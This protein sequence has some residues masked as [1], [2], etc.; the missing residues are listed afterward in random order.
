MFL[1]KYYNDIFSITFMDIDKKYHIIID[2][3]ISHLKYN[4]SGILLVFLIAI[5][6]FAY[7]MPT[8]LFFSPSGTDVYTHTYNTQNMADANS[9]F[10]FYE[11]S[12][13]NE[14]MGYD[15]P[16]GMWYFGSILMKVTGMSSMELA[17]ILPLT[18]LFILLILYYIFALELL[19]SSEGAILSTIFMISMPVLAIGMLNYSTSRFVVLFLI[20][21]LFIAL[22][23]PEIK[24][25]LISLI[26]VFTL[27]FSHTGTFMFLI[28]FSVMYFLI[29]A[30]V[31]KK[32]DRGFFILIVSLLFVYVQIAQ[33]FPFV[34]PQYI[35]KGRFLITMTD[36]LASI[37]GLG[38][39][40]EMGIIFYEN[41]FV[42]SNIIYALFWSSLLYV[43]AKF[44]IITRVRIEN[45][46]APQK[47][48][49]ALPII[50]NISQISHDIVAAPFWIG[51]VHTVLAVIGF[52]KLDA[53]GKCIFLAL[54]G[55][56]LVPGM[57]K[58][59]ENTGGTTSREIFYL[60]LIIPVAA[61]AGFYVLIP[62]VKRYTVKK[63]YSIPTLGIYA[64]ILIPLIV[65]PVI[66]SI[67][68]APVISGT[69]QERTNLQ[70]L[71]TTGNSF[72]GVAGPGY[73]ERIDLYAL[74]LTPSIESGSESKRYWDDLYKT[75]FYEGAEEY[76]HDLN[77]FNIK[78]ILQSDRTLKGFLEGATSLKIS[79]N[80]MLDRIYASDNNFSIYRY[81]SPQETNP[82]ISKE[83]FPLVFTSNSTSLQKYGSLFLFENDYYKVKLGEATPG[84]RYIGTTTEDLLGGGALADLLTIT[85]S[86]EYNENIVGYSLDDLDC[87]VTHEGNRIIYR[88]T[89]YDDRNTQKWATL[90]IKYIFYEKAFKREIVIA[91]D[92]QNFESS[93]KMN[94]GMTQM[95]FAPFNG[96]E[97]MQLT[98]GFEKPV[99]KHL[100]PSEDNVVLKD[101]TFSEIFINETEKGFLIR[102]G[103]TMPYPQRLVYRGS[104]YYDGV[105]NIMFSLNRYLNPSEPF[106][107]E[108]YYAVGTAEDSRDFI[109]EYTSVSR[110]DFA[111]GITPVVITGSAKDSDETGPVRE[112][113]ERLDIPYNQIQSQKE[114]EFMTNSTPIGQVNVYSNKKYLTQAEQ[115][116]A[117]TNAL[118]NT[119]ATGSL[120]AN[121]RYNLDSIRALSNAGGVYT[122]AYTVYPLYEKSDQS[123]YRE[124]KRAYIEG[125]RT[126]II[127]FPVSLPFSY[128]LRPQYES[129]ETLQQWSDII[130]GVL[131]N[132]GIAIF[133][134]DISDLAS[135]NSLNDIEEML[136]YAVQNGISFTTLDDTAAHDLMMQNVYADV[137]RDIDEVHLSITNTNPCQVKQATYR[138]VLPTIDGA[139]P[140]VVENGIMS[141]HYVTGDTA[142]IFV[143][144]DLNPGETKEVVVHPSIERKHFLIDTN[145]LF[146]G[147]STIVIMDNDSNPVM[148]ARITV[149]GKTYETDEEGRVSLNINRGEYTAVIEKPG[150]TSVR[151]VIEVKGIIKRYIRI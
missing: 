69:E 48:F 130:T 118:K 138:V 142:V 126:D 107:L 71:S 88:T 32:F 22:R 44:I 66:G 13:K 147:L 90:I 42:S 109:D 78:Y 23:K 8:V 113:F 108:Q 102:Y 120:F 98:E 1:K 11:E 50:G 133:Q 12:F 93:V 54:I 56:S 141:R 104:P 77:S 89:I 82:K 96:F 119:G 146:E 114:N 123:G 36:S 149:L 47:K 115:K 10:G 15:Y 7:F 30:V 148:N 52:F 16:F 105:G 61:A 131:T 41:I 103:N 68:Y 49:A 35:D 24:T 37:S 58:F 70:W 43:V 145:E 4:N 20:P 125:N 74:K 75:Y 27:G 121:Y 45:R 59:A 14:Y 19:K 3:I 122:G 79:K 63:H 33:Y 81:I 76:T 85:W 129:D 143:S 46:F 21:I 144:C 150:Y 112:M 18:A 83:E 51:P 128:L 29:Y 91:N 132:G 99:R 106:I 140:Y 94:C 40:S 38:F 151:F 139:A 64:L 9:L 137:T 135:T 5:C 60:F 62:L 116:S 55:T 117:I 34:Q 25:A 31:W 124:V 2:K 92:W 17:I 67:Y 39:F 101:T 97:I 127:L 6:F 134:W 111:G 57:M 100:Y 65:A 80:M 84:I 28:F 72:E 73:R 110:W 87:D 53:R 95:V 86:G 136:Y 26:L